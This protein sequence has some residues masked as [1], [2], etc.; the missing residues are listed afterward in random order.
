MYCWSVWFIVGLNGILWVCR[1]YLGLQVGLHVGRHVGRHVGLHVGLHGVLLAC[2]VLGHLH[3]RAFCADARCR[4][5][6]PSSRPAI[7]IDVHVQ[8]SAFT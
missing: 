6:A 1:V 3:R 4:R 8:R 2:A 7:C 5:C